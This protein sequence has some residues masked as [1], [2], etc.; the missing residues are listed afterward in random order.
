MSG[1]KTCGD[2]RCK[3]TEGKEV[4]YYPQARRGKLLDFLAHSRALGGGVREVVHL[5]EEEDREALS[6][7]VRVCSRNHGARSGG[8][9]AFRTDP[10][11]LYVDTIEGALLLKC[12]GGVRA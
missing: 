4:L 10:S 2:S 9:G 8:K 6:S 5:R 3:L 1:R 11:R 7:L 12:T